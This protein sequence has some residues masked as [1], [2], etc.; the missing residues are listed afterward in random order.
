MFVCVM[1]N[2]EGAINTQMRFYYFLSTAIIV[3]LIA[4]A[5]IYFGFNFKKDDEKEETMLT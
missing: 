4:W 2:I 1:C 3:N 5:A